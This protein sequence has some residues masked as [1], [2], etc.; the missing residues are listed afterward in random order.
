MKK[1][2]V[3]GTAPGTGKGGISSALVGY[4]KGLEE[5]N[6]AYEFIE[7]HNGEKNILI[8]WVKAFFLIAWLALTHR[9]SAV[10]W[11]HGGP[12][13]SSFRKF[14]LAIIPKLCGA[15]TLFHVHSPA[16]HDYLTKSSLSKFATKL[17]LLPFSK[18]VVL[19]PW[20]ADFIKQSGINKVMLVSANPNSPEYCQIAEQNL[21]VELPVKGQNEQVKIACMAR[22]VDGKG[23]DLV[24]RAM[25]HLPEH[26]ELIIA[27]DGNREN[28]YKALVSRLGLESRVAF[29]GWISG[30]E[31]VELL[32]SADLF[33][34]PS[35]YDSFGMV[36][37]EAMAFNLPVVAYNWGPI[38]DVVSSEVGLCCEKA[39]SEEVADCLHS[40]INNFKHYHGNG[41][42][43]VVEHYTP[44]AVVNNI[45]N[46]L[47]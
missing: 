41:P 33:C 25:T 30:A 15:T 37:I 13:L 43:K 40:V 10:F 31:K 3:V 45:L 2:F 27:G 9:S 12:W 44:H 26:V 38:G 18:L 23:V 16:F 6:V 29:L 42:K 14:T 4:L 5:S 46:E 35:R 20:W 36:F 28:D 39:E 17:L 24:I 11:F 19:T 21:K 7:S 1:I 32:T 47:T 34:L 22:L 8:L